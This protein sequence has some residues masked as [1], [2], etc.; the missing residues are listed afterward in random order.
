MKRQKVLG[1]WTAIGIGAGAAIGAASNSMGVWV[2][3]GAAV[4]IIIGSLID[5]QQNH[6]DS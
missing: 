4:G 1:A 2:A 5:K 6:T 3:V